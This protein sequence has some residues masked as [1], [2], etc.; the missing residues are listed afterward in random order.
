MMNTFGLENVVEK[1]LD[2][3]PRM[4]TKRSKSSIAL[5]ARN[6]DENIHPNMMAVVA[7]DL[8][9]SSSFPKK[10]QQ[11]LVMTTPDAKRHKTATSTTPTRHITPKSRQKETTS[12]E[13]TAYTNDVPVLGDRSKGIQNLQDRP[14]REDH[15]S[16]HP[17]ESEIAENKIVAEQVMMDEEEES[18]VDIV[19]DNVDM[20]YPSEVAVPSRRL[21]ASFYQQA[22]AAD[23]SGVRDNDQVYLQP[24]G[25]LSLEQ[26]LLPALAR[27][28]DKALKGLQAKVLRDA[29]E[30][31]HVIKQSRQMVYEGIGSAIQHAHQARLNR[32]ACA[33]ELCQQEIQQRA[34]AKKQRLEQEQQERRRQ[35]LLEQQELDLEQSN[36]LKLLKRQYPRN[37]SL[38]REVVQLMTS[39]SKLEKEERLWQQAERQLLEKEAQD[40]DA[41]IKATTDITIEEEQQ[42]LPVEI[43]KDELHLQ[44][45]QL[46]QDMSISSTRIQEGLGLVTKIVDESDQMRKQLYQT[47]R[48]DHQFY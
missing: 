35:L 2:V 43:P 29:P 7:K 37:Q 18:H 33:Q 32:Q 34:L 19:L 21:V 17:H 46:V 26:V 20:E 13:A 31:A 14:L 1:D 41:T 44:L 47:Y 45:D 10:Q 16:Q 24:A 3:T 25:L 4:V 39:K 30:H 12:E 11:A 22:L 15:A 23:D 28:E 38:W 48:R 42:Q 27:Q 36:R 8:P 5:S 40:G 9:S 6:D